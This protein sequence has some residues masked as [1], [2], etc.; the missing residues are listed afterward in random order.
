MNSSILKN[1]DKNKA[2]ELIIGILGVNV[3]FLLVGIQYE[4]ITTLKYNNS[5]SG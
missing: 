4:K 3:A 1:V 2:V 5:K